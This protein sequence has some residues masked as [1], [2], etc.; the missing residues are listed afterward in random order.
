MMHNSDSLLFNVAGDAGGGGGAAAAPAW[1][2]VIVVRGEDGG[3][4][5]NDPAQWLDRAPKP[6]ADFVRSN[7][8]AAR[9]RT[10]GMVRVPGEGASADEV[11]AFHKA[12]GVPD[13]PEDYGLKALER[14]PDGLQHD[15]EMEKAFLGRARELGLTRKQVESLRDFQ[16]NYLGESVARQR[17]IMTQVIDAEK[18][19]LGARFGSG[20]DQALATARTLATQA[21][22]PEGMRKYIAHGALDPQS[23]EF[24]GPD[25]LEFAVAVARATGEDRG[26]GGLRGAGG[27]QVDLAAAKDIMSN[28]N[29]PL[30]KEYLKGSGEV[31]QRVSAAY[32]AAYPG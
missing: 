20:L 10:E 30:N 31:F 15:A 8:T 32:K 7:M 28:P 4:R 3:E 24:A 2:E 13:R 21:W 1:H 29:N 19:E 22:V 14:M 26:A 23:G 11:A 5:L 18:Q 17:L 6:L 16:V 12:L 27:M 9:Q 25:F